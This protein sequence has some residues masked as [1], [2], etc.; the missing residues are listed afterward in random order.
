MYNS[1]LDK[2]ETEKAIVFIKK[3]F[4][5]YFE[6]ELNLMKICSPLFINKNTGLNDHLSGVENPV[7]FQARDA[8]LEIAQSLAKWKRNELKELSIKEYCGIWTNMKAIRADENDETPFHSLYVEQFDWEMVIREE[9]RNVDFLKMIVSKIYNVFLKTEKKI[10][11]KYSSLVKKL[12][13][14]LTFITSEELLAKYPKLSAKERENEFGKEV[15]AFFI[16]GIGHTLSNNIKHDNRA[17]DYDDWNLN[18]DLFFYSKI[19]QKSIEI[20]SMGIRVD[21]KSLRTQM[22][23]ARRDLKKEFKYHNDIL[24]NKLPFTIGGG[25]GQS[26]L[27]LFFLEKYHIGEFQ[28]SYWSEKH[29]IEMKK[30]GIELK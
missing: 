30:K 29:R 28:R 13:N 3:T 12:P 2:I 15:G 22:E 21:Q 16:I 25:I 19:H 23:I 18:G 24:N 27:I 9:D 20:S 6:K 1:K 26:R 17:A 8:N 10:N 11:I 4:I 14:K 7:I 5:E